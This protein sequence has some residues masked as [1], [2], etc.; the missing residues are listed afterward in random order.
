MWKLLDFASL[1][2]SPLGQSIFRDSWAADTRMQASSDEQMT[3]E[4][5]QV[6]SPPGDLQTTTGD[7]A[8]QPDWF[9]PLT[10]T[11]PQISRQYRT[12]TAGNSHSQ[13]G[14][15][16]AETPTM[17]QGYEEPA[18]VWGAND[19]HVALDPW[20]QFYGRAGPEPGWYDYGNL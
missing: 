18:W 4:E 1:H 10:S 7:Y 3:M 12:Q 17:R 6:N 13:L 8:S 9:S 20:T 2:R 11:S 5:P 19:S 15:T 16:A 14:L